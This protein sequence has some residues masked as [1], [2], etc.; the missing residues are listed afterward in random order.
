MCRLYGFLANERTKVEC[1]LV[2]AQN[3]LLHQSRA[4]IRF[5]EMKTMSFNLPII[6]HYQPRVA[7]RELANAKQLAKA[8]EREN[9]A[10]HIR[11]DFYELVPTR[12]EDAPTLH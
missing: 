9:A 4:D 8:I 11:P 2:H 12:L 1:S 5:A 7:A 3:A 6:S 10:L